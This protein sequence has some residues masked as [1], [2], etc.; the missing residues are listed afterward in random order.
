ML[1]LGVL[2]ASLPSAR[3]SAACQAP[4]DTFANPFTKE[5]AHHRPIGSG[6]VFADTN[7]PSTISLLRGGFGNINSNNGWGINIY[8][9]TSADPLLTVTH[10]GP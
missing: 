6:A 1:A 9:S 8:E 3:A 5:S 10:A 4:V 2:V 7:D